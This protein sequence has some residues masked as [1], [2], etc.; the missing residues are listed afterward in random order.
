MSAALTYTDESKAR[1]KDALWMAIK[2]AASKRQFKYVA[3]LKQKI[4]ELLLPVN[5]VGVQ[6][7][8]ARIYTGYQICY[9]ISLFSRHS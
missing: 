4:K 1:E 3:V 8:V 2:K 6:V 9:S 5:L 7:G